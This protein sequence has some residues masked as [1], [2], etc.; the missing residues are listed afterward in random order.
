[1]QSGLQPQF[2][3][4]GHQDGMA[5]QQPVSSPAC[6]SHAP[7]RPPTQRSHRA[8]RSRTSPHSP[9]SP[10]CPRV[11]TGGY[12]PA[13]P[14]RCPA[15]G[16]LACARPP[17]PVRAR[18]GGPQAACQ[19]P[20]TH[21][22]L[23][24]PRATGEHARGLGARA[25]Q[26]AAGPAAPGGL[27]GP[28]CGSAARTRGPEAG[29]RGPEAF[30]ATHSPGPYAPA[31]V[32]RHRGASGARPCL[33][34]ASSGGCLLPHHAPSSLRSK[35]SRDRR[36][37]VWCAKEAKNCLRCAMGLYLMYYDVQIKLSHSNAVFQND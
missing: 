32:R 13:R 21:G 8:R 2:P 35:M 36:T 5:V 24:R 23:P 30:G 20:R 17:V 4:C 3:C 34:S 37:R 16:V 26:H 27:G 31:N 22:A 12:S 11:H 10:S 7:T 19:R 6:I 1:M 18:P 33:T 28:S 14:A 9:W 15:C 25:A 29:M